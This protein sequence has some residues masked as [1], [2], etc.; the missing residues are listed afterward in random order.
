MCLSVYMFANGCSYVLCG[1]GIA[2]PLSYTLWAE[3]CYFD[4]KLFFI[5]AKLQ[6]LAVE[7]KC[8]SQNYPH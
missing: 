7:R 1:K 4:F 6:N 8:D 5:K 3:F 2:N